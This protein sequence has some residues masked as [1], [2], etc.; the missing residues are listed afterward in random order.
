D[1]DLVIRIACSAD[2]AFD[3]S[4]E[5]LRAAETRNDNG[6]FLGFAQLAPHIKRV[7]SPVDS[8][9]C[10]RTL[11]FQVSFDCAPRSF[12]LSRFLANIA[13]AGIFA[14]PP[15]VEHAWNMMNSVSSL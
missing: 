3:T 15:V 7:G 11:A 13:R 4:L 1:H 12:E 6:D 9:V 2:H 5:Q 10:L 14:A 8:N